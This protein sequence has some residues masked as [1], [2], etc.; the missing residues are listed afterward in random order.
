MRGMIVHHA[1]AVA[2]AKLVPA[3]SGRRDLTSLAERIA[4]SQIVE[5]RM[6]RRWLGERGELGAD[7]EHQGHALMPGMLTEAELAELVSL[8]GEAFEHRFLE[9]MIRHH[10]G[11]LSMVTELFTVPGGGREPELWEFASDIEAAQRSEVAL[12]RRLLAAGR[13][14][15]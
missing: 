14:G 1:Q 15:V 7:G 11:A 4:V 9:Q 10:Q 5:M 2:M 3:R 13:P 12:M 6:M 8:T